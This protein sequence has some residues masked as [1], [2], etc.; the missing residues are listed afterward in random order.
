MRTLSDMCD[1]AC[2]VGCAPSPTTASASS[3][4]AAIRQSQVDKSNIGTP[5]ACR[6]NRLPAAK[7]IGENINTAKAW[8][9]KS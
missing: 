4:T 6:N 9:L 1:S 7:K 8:T 2:H 5:G 3:G